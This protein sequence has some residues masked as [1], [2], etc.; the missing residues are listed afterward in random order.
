[1][2]RYAKL[3]TPVSTLKLSGKLTSIG[4]GSAEL[5]FKDTEK[6]NATKLRSA[7][8][9]FDKSKNTG[10]LL[11]NEAQI[12]ADRRQIVQ[13]IFRSFVRGGTVW[14]SG[15]CLLLNRVQ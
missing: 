15:C 9:A 14:I 13:R 12:L 3:E 10:L 8:T 6:I 4:E 7:F 5:G 2:Q 11:I 1:M